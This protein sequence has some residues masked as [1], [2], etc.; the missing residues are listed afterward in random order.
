MAGRRQRGVRSGIVSKRGAPLTLCLA[1]LPAAACAD[2]GR[3][4]LAIERPD[5]PE[6]DPF[7]LDVDSLTLT[8]W[9][10]ADNLLRSVR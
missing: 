2:S 4:E 1:L 3:V 9:A 8:A 7:A 10:G 5:D 6:L